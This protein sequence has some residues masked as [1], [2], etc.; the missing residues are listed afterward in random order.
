MGARQLDSGVAKA[1]AGSSGA[2]KGVRLRTGLLAIIISFAAFSIVPTVIGLMALNASDT[3]RKSVEHLSDIRVDVQSVSSGV[4]GAQAG[5]RGYAVANDPVFRATT[6][7]AMDD[8]QASL[9]QMVGNVRS[10]ASVDPQAAQTAV[11]DLITRVGESLAL[12]D[13]NPDL[14]LARIK[15]GN[16]PQ[17]AADIQ[18][19][20]NLIN[21]QVE[22][23]A[24]D[25]VQ[26]ADDYSQT[27][28]IA[29]I[30]GIIGSL[31]TI[32]IVA[33][34]MIRSIR[35]PIEEL[36]ESSRALGGGHED[37]SV[38]PSGAREIQSLGAS[39]N[40][41][42]AQLKERRI[43]LEQASQAKSEFLARMS[44]ELRTPLNAILGFGQL[45]E[46]DDL[47]EDERSSVQQILRAGRHLLGLIDEV[48]DISR[49]ESGSLRIS[50][51]TVSLETVFGDVESMIAPIASDRKVTLN[52]EPV[53][54]NLHVKADQ[55]R[56]KQ[57]LLNLLSNGIKYNRVGGVLNVSSL[58]MGDE[59]KI[60]VSDTGA[61]IEPDRV[62]KL[63][64]PFER[65]GAE[66]KGFTEGTGLG[67]ALSQRLA[68]LMGG[69]LEL[70]STSDVG[71]T[72]SVRLGVASSPGGVV[73]P[74]VKLERPTPSSRELVVVCIE[75]NV[76]NYELVT[77]ILD[78][79]YDSKVYTSIQGSIG[80]DLVREH[81]PH[82][83]LLDL[84]LPDIS[85]ERVLEQLKSDPET[86]DVPILI[87]SADATSGHQRRLIHKGAMTY[88]TKPLDVK[89][90]LNKVEAA[91]KLNDESKV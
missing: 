3:A 91:L 75:D 78:Q 83:V 60:L 72:F 71:T 82:V 2:P 27:L 18:T 89:E 26:R 43:A 62:E 32:V 58:P 88:L 46:M 10:D 52:V 19:E 6:V 42:A 90:F 21:D 12:A 28:R 63:F 57:I 81:K 23:E 16:G 67:L 45:L 20:L 48:L 47:E 65:L 73:A 59:I 22:A 64:V 56:L 55:Q 41:M 4:L 51:E 77:Q 37:V 54:A 38:T 76:S 25:E 11:E 30:V 33:I 49:I 9:D 44:H 5:I 79:N 53:V 70:E 69:S 8:L 74:R 61:G 31:L 34:Y 14:V 50:L 36:D 87:M 68:S 29:S 86:K 24:S 13:R 39:F 84:H 85:G 7:T 40:E 35:G 17:I 15:E 1:V 80:V 66:Q